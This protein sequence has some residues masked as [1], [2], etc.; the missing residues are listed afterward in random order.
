MNGRALILL[1]AQDD[2]GAARAIIR[3]IAMARPVL[4]RTRVASWPALAAAAM[5]LLTTSAAA[6][7]IIERDDR[8]SSRPSA[9]APGQ[10]QRPAEELGL[11]GYVRAP[12]DTPVSGG[13]VVLQWLSRSVTAQIDRTGRFHLMPATDG[14]Q[15]LHVIVRGLAPYRVLVTVPR[16][17]TLRLP[18]IRLAPATYFQVRFVSAAGE[19]LASP[20]IRRRSM[21]V[22]GMPVLPPQE[23]GVE[24]AIESDGLVVAGPLPRGLTTMALDTAGFAQTRLPDLHVTGA[25]TLLDGGTVI[26]EPGAVLHVDVVDG[27]GAPLAGHEVSLAD[28]RPLSPLS[29]ARAQTNLQGRA[30]FDRLA[31][32]QYLVSTRASARCG[33]QTLVTTRRVSVSGNGTLRTRLIAGGTATFRVMSPFAPMSGVAVSASPDS[34][35]SSSPATSGRAGAVLRSRGPMPRTSGASCGGSTDAEGRVVLSTFPPGPARVHVRLPNSTYVRRVNVPV[36]GQETALLVP[37]G[38]LPVHVIDALTNK[39]VAGAA[40]TWTGAGA[41]IEATTVASGDALLEGVGATQGTLL[42]MA[43]GYE[44]AEGKL[45]EPPA[46]AFEV[47]LVPTRPALLRARVITTTGEPVAHAIVELAPDDPMALGH[48]AA[49]AADGV[50]TFVDAPPGTLNLTASAEGFAAV[51]S[52]ITADNREGVVLTLPRSQ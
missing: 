40:I 43:N 21:D 38:F 18:A 46:I 44:R 15:E 45:S 41:R 34:G 12:D 11:S 39:P 4:G 50:V 14:L 8:G 16:S 19:P 5:G 17:R 27:T 28:A 51:T 31:A 25:D 52:R 47:G 42:V 35:T 7:A 1:P 10:P 22:N 30:R 2:V 20:R 23:D 36:G 24:T 32:G 26:V 33:V 29:S 9:L 37:D 13:T 48:I 3:N 49:A 6:D